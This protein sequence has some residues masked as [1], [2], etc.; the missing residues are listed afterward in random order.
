MVL[1]FT[2]DLIFV[3][4]VNSYDIFMILFLT[5]NKEIDNKNWRD[6]EPFLNYDDANNPP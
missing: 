6:N 4:V 2:S 1:L 5:E 3:N